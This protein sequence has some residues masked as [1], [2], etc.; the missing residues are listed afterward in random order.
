MGLGHTDKDI[1]MTA[2]LVMLLLAV[3]IV[4]AIVFAVRQSNNNKRRI[5]E[6][7][8]GRGASEVVIVWNWP[9]GDRDNYI[10]NVEYI[11][12]RG[13]HRATRCKVSNGWFNSGDIYWS[14]PPTV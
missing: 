4:F 2:V 12:R 8:V 9:G 11:D 14:D 6:Y 7:L 5:S 10:Y 1:L 3:V 13:D